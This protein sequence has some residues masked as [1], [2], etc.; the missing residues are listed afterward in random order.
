MRPDGR[1]GRLEECLG[2]SGGVTTK[3]IFVLITAMYRSKEDLGQLHN[4]DD[5]CYV[6]I[7]SDSD[8][9][10]FY[11]EKKAEL[12]E[13]S[14]DDEILETSDAYMNLTILEPPIIISDDDDDSNDLEVPMLIEG[15]LCDRGRIASSEK[16]LDEFAVSQCNSL[17][18]TGE[19][20]FGGNL[21]QPPNDPEANL[22]ISNRKLPTDE[23][24][25]PV[26]KQPKK[27][28]EKTKNICVP[29]AVKG[30]KNRKPSK[31][32]PSVAEIEKCKSGNAICKVPG[33][34]LY[35]IENSKRY[36][37][38]NF[39]QN[40]DELVQKI[41]SLIN[42][43]VFDKKM[44][45][46]IDIGWNKKMLR[47][48]G[49]CATSEIRYPKRKRYARIEIA[50]KVCDSADRLRD[51]LIHEVCH[52]ASW[53]LDGIRD[54]HGD[55]WKYYARKS[56][57]VHPELP[58]VTRCHNYSLNYKILYECTQCKARIGRYTKSLDT[59]RFICAR[60][61]GS[62]VMLPSTRKDGTPIVPHVRPFAKYVQQ[63]Y[64]KVM[65]Q[66]ATVDHGDVMR[67]LSEN[68][69]QEKGS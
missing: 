55:A 2:L 37:G 34:F 44:P 62:L 14:S 8:D 17:D 11:E 39:K 10:Y 29:P 54:S 58:L 65:R 6:V 4:Q 3:H 56:N 61:M 64:R 15:D 50:L 68:Y 69:K 60:C 27:R 46:K 9:E 24:S 13:I 28:K 12:V 38:K 41:Y 53:L 35:G 47:T 21:H 42:S 48:A 66:I 63:N 16:E 36:S 26:V 31:K 43:S 59:T 40:K 52:A 19:Q 25:V 7:D 1:G 5:D 57:M 30:Q 45:E 33:C 49:V 20:D 18:D 32:K 51:T 23:K 22:E 67:K